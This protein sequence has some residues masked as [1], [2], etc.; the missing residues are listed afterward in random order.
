MRTA[1][2]RL[3]GVVLL[4]ALWCMSVGC[5]ANNASDG[6][7]QGSGG[8][9]DEAASGGPAGS[10]ATGGADSLPDSGGG[11]TPAAS[12]GAAT[13]P[14]TG[15]EAGTSLATGGAGRP[16]SGG[17]AGNAT[18]GD[19]AVDAAA[20]AN[21]GG[22][23]SESGGSG[24]DSG[25]GSNWPE[26]KYITLNEVHERLQSDDPD[27]LLVNVVD[28]EF[29]D[30]GHIAG[31]LKIPWDT[32]EDHLDQIDPNRHV[33]I[34]CRRGVRSESA[35]PVLTSNGYALVW[36]MEGGIEAWIAEGY[37]TVSD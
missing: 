30:L 19:A 15:G 4:L 29:Y 7:P 23:S 28:E 13:P 6:G 21:A 27:M 37:P 18:G 20:G 22:T 3:R 17:G 24:P 9:N 14:A 35:Y 33:V 2:A 12:G 25:T 34:Y 26:G 1:G 8:V 31:S 32:L 16:A 10:P 36:V 11:G 5:D